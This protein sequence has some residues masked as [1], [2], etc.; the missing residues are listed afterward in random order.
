M[1]PEYLKVTGKSKKK[2]WLVEHL[3]DDEIEQLLKL[4]KLKFKQKKKSK[5]GLLLI[6]L[7]QRLP[8][9]RFALAR[10]SELFRKILEKA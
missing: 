7:E 3:T 1:I 8:R 9:T 6:A 2:L 4:K 5:V 10:A